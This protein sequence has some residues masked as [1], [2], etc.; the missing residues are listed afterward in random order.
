MTSLLYWLR[1]EPDS[2]AQLADTLRAEIRDPLWMLARQWQLG[3]LGGEDTGSPAHVEITRRLRRLDGKLALEPDQLAVRPTADLQMR[4]G[5]AELLLDEIGDPIAA[6]SLRAF[7]IELVP[8]T[9]PD[10]RDRAG[11][12]LYRTART[13]WFDGQRAIGSG[14]SGAVRGRFGDGDLSARFDA[15]LPVV[16]TWLDAIGGFS[17]RGRLARSWDSSRLRYFVEGQAAE[18]SLLGA[19]GPDGELDWCAYDAQAPRGAPAAPPPAEPVVRVLPAFVSFRGMPN[20]RFWDF[21]DG[22]VNLDAVVNGPRELTKALALEFMTVHGNDWF[23]VP[24]DQDVG[25]CSE[26]V[27]LVVVDVFGVTRTIAPAAS[28][29]PGWGMF[30]PTGRPD[31]LVVPD[32]LGAA[33]LRG[34]PIEETHFV[35]DEVANLG[36]SIESRVRSAAGG[37][38]T[39]AS[40]PVPS[41]APPPGWSYELL[42]EFRRN[43]L[44]YQPTKGAD[45][46]PVL[47]ALDAIDDDRQPLFNST[48]NC[49]RTYAPVDHVIHDEEIGRAGVRIRLHYHLARDADGRMHLWASFDRD[50]G[51]GEVRS[52][53]EFDS[54]RRG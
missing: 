50:L 18:I 36:W 54:V 17:S 49:V 44:P 27:S 28:I 47:R 9:A 52:E 37:S 40:A 48:R 23:V 16:E 33:A 22:G 13:R 8:L 26:I 42:R 30:N 32:T 10:P 20:H 38:F 31:L 39:R 41:P 14:M 25:T 3:E 21:E 4:I 51:I 5:A 35:R 19:P 15:A 2:D 29:D 43:W 6:G 12:R 45:G 1:V 34:A 53:I 46:A 11:Q 24:M 7:L